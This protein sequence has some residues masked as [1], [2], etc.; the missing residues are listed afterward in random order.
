M[1]IVILYASFG[2]GHLKAAEA[3]REYY[4]TTYPN[5]EV[6]FIDAL[7][8]TNPELNTLLTKTYVQIAKNIPKAWGKIYDIADQATVTD[9]T[10]VLTKTVAKKFN[11]LILDFNPDIILCTHP[12]AVDMLSILKKKDKLDAKIG[13]VLTDYASHQLWLSQPETVDAFF[14]AHDVMVSELNLQ[15][16]DKKHVFA[17][18]IPVLNKFTTALDNTQILNDF[19]FDKDIFTVLFFPGGEYGLAKNNNIFKALLRISN[20]QI[21][22]VTGRNEKLKKS[23]EKLA[24][25]SR[26]KIQILGYTDK[27]PELLSIS[28]IA[29]TKP[30]GLT[31]SECIVTNTPIVVCSPLPGQEE[32]NSNYILNNGLGFRIFENSNKLLTIRSIINN[33]ERLKQVKEIGKVL[34]KPNAAKDICEKMIEIYNDAK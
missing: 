14:V 6:M 29:I 2:G 3:L 15:G 17:T 24:S 9:F 33:K 5:Y 27:I 30:G 25:H 18:G 20:I 4:R 19:G 13:L 7:K 11:N 12:F 16:I 8:Y 23:F 21:V 10:A 26:K 31:T 32:H 22:T 28:D 1:K 34:A